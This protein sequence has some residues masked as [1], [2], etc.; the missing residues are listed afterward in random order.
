MSLA[1]IVLPTGL[2]GDYLTMQL[3]YYS[4]RFVSM[5]IVHVNEN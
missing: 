2:L 1:S 5:D 3:I 4:P